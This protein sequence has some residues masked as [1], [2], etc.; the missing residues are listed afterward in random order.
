[1]SAE[2]VY[3]LQVRGRSVDT[4]YYLQV[5]GRGCRHG[6]LSAGARA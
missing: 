2:K 6:V 4:V 5:R 1:M 3:Y